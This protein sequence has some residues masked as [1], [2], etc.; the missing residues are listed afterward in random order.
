MG[1]SSPVKI[2]L[3]RLLYLPA[4]QQTT[5]FV[6]LHVFRPGRTATKHASGVSQT[7]MNT[8]GGDV[9]LQPGC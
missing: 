8:V 3:Q 6:W 2:Q 1:P 4:L 7:C 9:A 5:E